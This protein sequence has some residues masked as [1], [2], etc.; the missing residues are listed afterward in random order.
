MTE[1]LKCNFHI[2]KIFYIQQ[3]LVPFLSYRDILQSN[4][5]MSQV[6]PVKVYRLPWQWPEMPAG[7]IEVIL[8]RPKQ[9]RKR[10]FFSFSIKSNCYLKDPH[11]GSVTVIS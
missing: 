8:M 9:W 6:G 10:I 1:C 3:I 4:V 11:M 2:L 7:R 5:F